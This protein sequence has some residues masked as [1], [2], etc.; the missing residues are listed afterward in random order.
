[1]SAFRTTRTMGGRAYV[2]IWS[3]TTCVPTGA[4]TN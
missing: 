1:M 2:D 4:A 3:T